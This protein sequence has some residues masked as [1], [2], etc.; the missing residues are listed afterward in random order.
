MPL[1]PNPYPN[2]SPFVTDV[3]VLF[4]TVYAQIV[5]IRA[6]LGLPPMQPL[7]AGS[8]GGGFQIGQEFLQQ[9]QVAPR[10]VIVP[11]GGDFDFMTTMPVGAISDPRTSPRKP[12]YSEWAKFEAYIWGDPDLTPRPSGGAA[13]PAPYVPNARF[14][15]NTTYEL[16]R[17]FISAMY[18]AMTGGSFRPTSAAW[19]QPTDNVRYGR[20]YVLSFQIRVPIEQEPYVYLAYSTTLGD[21]GVEGVTTVNLTDPTGANPEPIGIVIAPPK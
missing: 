17:E 8:T 19:V 7:V 3:N 21:G 15:F 10:I 2:P 18:D 12:I 4:D 16:R 20:V 5:T 11:T 13:G 6:G 9:Q 1:P 14:D